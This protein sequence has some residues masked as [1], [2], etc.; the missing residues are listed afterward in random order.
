MGNETL[1][2]ANDETRNEF[3]ITFVWMAKMETHRQQAAQIPIENST[4]SVLWNLT[5]VHMKLQIENRTHQIRIETTTG[6]RV[7]FSESTCTNGIKHVEYLVNP[8]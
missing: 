8:L 6:I 7:G 2:S 5:M 4:I 3:K 1:K